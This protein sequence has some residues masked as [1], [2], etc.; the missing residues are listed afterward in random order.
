[1]QRNRSGRN[2]VNNSSRNVGHLIIISGTDCVFSMMKYNVENA[3]TFRQSIVSGVISRIGM[4]SC[5]SEGIYYLSFSPFL[6]ISIWP[7]EW[8]KEERER[9]LNKYFL[10]PL[11]ANNSLL[12]LSSLKRKRKEMRVSRKFL[13]YI[14]NKIRV[15]F[16]TRGWI[17]NFSRCVI[18]INNI[19]II[20]YSL[21]GTFVI[22]NLLKIPSLDQTN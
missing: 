18:L 4:E 19:T 6:R 12:F 5:R 10:S 17:I 16:L 9:K 15:Q 11:F 20:K 3:W 2:D 14:E 8:N 22:T 21:E 13:I 7:D 1:M